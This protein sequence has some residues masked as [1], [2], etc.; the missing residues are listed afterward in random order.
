MGT[1]GLVSN[2]VGSPSSKVN[3]HENGVQMFLT[4]LS[5]NLQ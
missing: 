1:K 3:R 5:G 4:L 2:E